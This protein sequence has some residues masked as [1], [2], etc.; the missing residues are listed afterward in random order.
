ME[1]KNDNIHKSEAQDIRWTNE[2][3]QIKNSLTYYI[4]N[5]IQSR[6]I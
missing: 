5:V 4:Q 6:I 3:R 2:L 1:N